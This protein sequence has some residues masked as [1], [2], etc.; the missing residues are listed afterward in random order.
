MCMLN[1]SKNINENYA[2]RILRIDAIEP[3][4][5]AHSIV[6]AIL[7]TD[8]VV[9][10][11]HA[12]VGD[13]VAFFPVGSI[14][15]SEF[16]SKN[17]MYS[18]AELNENWAQYQTKCQSRD[19][20]MEIPEKS[21]AEFAKLEE[22]TKQIKSMTG[23]FNDQGRV[24]MIK[25]RGVFSEGFVTPVETLEIAFPEL[26]QVIWSRQLG[27]IFD[28]IGEKKLCWKYVPKGR[29]VEEQ[30][31]NKTYEHHWWK[32]K[33][34][35]LKKFDRMVDGQFAFHYDTAHLE[36]NAHLIDP[37]DPIT[38]TVKAH[39]TSGIFS[40]LL[41]KKKLT[42][43]EQFKKFLHLKVD[44]TE[45]GNIYSSRK[46]IQN[47]YINENAGKSRFYSRDAYGPVNE[48]LKDLLAPGM[49]V[50][51]EIVGY[52]EGTHTCIQSPKGID[53]DYGCAPGRWKFMP[54]RITFTEP[55]GKVQEYE[56]EEVIK[57]TKQVMVVL[58]GRADWLMPMELLYSGK[59]GAMYYDL[60]SR[61]D[62]QTTQE[63]YDQAVADYKKDPQYNGYLP[64]YLESRTE[65]AKQLWRVEWIDKM[66]NDKEMLG[67]ELH[68]PL[69]NTK[70]A[71]REG[72]VL[73]IKHDKEQRA[74]KLKTR[75]HAEL[76]Q[77]S[78]DSGEVDMEDMA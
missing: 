68:E 56:V 34:K 58:G 5:D 11:K 17:N 9:V 50:Y 57:W 43:W 59:A 48:L 13:I 55:D 75:A 42:R 47:K 39:G 30:A 29:E 18:N 10:G 49:T 28:E 64:K 37:N 25:L 7:G 70:K 65:Y 31:T 36:K 46:V 41:T 14:I 38:L 54:Y 76:A 33:Q 35:K 74:L 6:R 16:L 60:W 67:M 27:T 63:Q 22:I 78:A 32:L 73:R 51:G 4:P 1:K 61:M 77:R 53:H 20:L 12:K 15:C 26:K 44:E 40:N 19:A 52:L 45:Y 69:C 71:P 3:I 8:K 66:R 21:E 2:C 62:V 23:M 72:V 24:R